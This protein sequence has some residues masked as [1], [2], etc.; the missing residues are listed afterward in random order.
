MALS[1]MNFTGNEA[2]QRHHGYNNNYRQQTQMAVKEKSHHHQQQRPSIYAL[3]GKPWSVFAEYYGCESS[4]NIIVPF[5]LQIT[6]IV[7]MEILS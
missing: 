2:Q 4:K 3:K 7:V 1:H 6:Y 5:K